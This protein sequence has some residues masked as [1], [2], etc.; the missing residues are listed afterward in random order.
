M[1]V[2][3]L[4]AKVVAQAAG[5]AMTSAGIPGGAEAAEVI[6]PLLDELL[7][8]Q[9]EQAEAI[10][11]IDANVQRLIDGPWETARTYI[12]EAAVAQVGPEERAD[13]LRN[14]SVALHS[15]VPLQPD[16]TL[17]RA[18]ACLQLAVVERMLGDV[19]SSV[20]QARRAL[21]AATSFVIA[22][23]TALKEL[24]RAKMRGSI[25]LV[26]AF[27]MAARSGATVLKLQSHHREF[28]IV[29]HEFTGI[30]DAA[31]ELCGETDAGLQQC[32]E[33]LTSE[34]ARLGLGKL[35]TKVGAK[36]A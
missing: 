25:E 29:W 28:P 4:T 35:V 13:K 16:G 23:L 6:E 11:R 12:E 14:A 18:Y 10:A 8:V 15:A 32:A 17:Q 22:E 30:R 9:D 21:Q 34:I 3:E 20:L 7:H 5:G 26:V 27:P 33:L 1:G 36:D 19:G 2:A 31:T 24:K